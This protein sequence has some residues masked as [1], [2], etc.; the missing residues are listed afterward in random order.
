MIFLLWGREKR[1]NII[2]RGLIFPLLPLGVRANDDGP[3]QLLHY[4]SPSPAHQQYSN[5]LYKH[6]QPMT[7]VLHPT[8]D[9]GMPNGDERNFIYIFMMDQFRP[10]I[11]HTHTYKYTRTHTHEHTCSP[12]LVC[13]MVPACTDGE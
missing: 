5:L 11:K 9:D 6:A 13:F 3:L 2:E 7:M 1:R 4:P 10:S 12:I 8:R